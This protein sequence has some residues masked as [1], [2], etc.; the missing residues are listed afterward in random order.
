MRYILLL[1][2]LLPQFIFAQENES[3][4]IKAKIK[5]GAI[6]IG[7]TLN[8]SAYSTTD[9]FASTGKTLEG[10]RINIIAKTKNGYFIY[11]DFVVG[12][13]LTLDH[14]RLKVSSDS[15]SDNQ[16]NNRTFMLIGPFTRYYLD[17]GIFGE[18]SA[19]VGLLNFSKSDK[20]NLIE[21]G[22]GVGYAHFINEKFSIEPTLSV[23]YFQQT[24]RNKKYTSIGPMLGVGIQAYLLRKKANVIK[25]A[26]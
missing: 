21:S 2:L 8:A 19:S 12:V 17:N 15:D 6:L 25:R 10:S 20:F 14:Q 11:H 16:S 5:Q 13:D 18:L 22:A 7:G 24:L 3:Y 1:L 23:K 4:L 9:Q 26:L